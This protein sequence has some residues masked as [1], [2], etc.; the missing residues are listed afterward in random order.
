MNSD[1]RNR[2]LESE[3]VGKWTC[4]SDR[5]KCEYCFLPQNEFSCVV[6]RPGQSSYNVRGYWDIVGQQLRIGTSPTAAE[7]AEILGFKRSCFSAQLP[8]GTVMRFEKMA[9]A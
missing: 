3:L 8:G 1:L 2:V 5:E 7:P 6:M 4:S 9:S